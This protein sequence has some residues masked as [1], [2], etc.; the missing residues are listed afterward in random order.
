MDNQT[1]CLEHLALEQWNEELARVLLPNT[2][3]LAI[4]LLIGIIGNA[5]VLYINVARIYSEVRFFIPVLSA[6]DLV[7]V[8][9]NCCFS[10][11]INLLPVKFHSDIL[12]K[13]IWFITLTSTCF[14]SVILLIIAVHR[15]LKICRP[16]GKQMTRR[17]KRLLIVIGLVFVVV[18]TSPSF[19]FYGS[20]PVMK[21]DKHLTGFRCTSVTADM[22]AFAFVFKGGLFLAAATEL[23][24]LVV[25]Y[26]FIARVLFQQKNFASQRNRRSAVSLR[27]TS[28]P[29]NNVRA[30]MADREQHGIEMNKHTSVSTGTT[31]ESEQTTNDLN[32]KAPDTV[33]KRKIPSFRI[34]VMFM[35]I[36]A[37]YIICNIPPLS[38]MV[39]ESRKA[40]FWQTMSDS[41]IG[42]FRFLYTMFIINNIANPFIYGFL[43][44]KFQSQLR[45]IFC[46]KRS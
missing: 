45:K 13:G 6:V 1:E 25:L 32:S 35:V 30:E 5:I 2:V 7:A 3:C 22:E 14:S 29:Y 43:D 12:C 4:Y 18:I 31:D 37:V 19:V 33:R 41:E 44:K 36:T 26:S 42:I 27:R 46:R 17:W 11:S 21:S 8:I 24:V 39:L 28:G 34:T 15:Y 9:A 10:M 16:F 38:L 40:D 20:A 23:I